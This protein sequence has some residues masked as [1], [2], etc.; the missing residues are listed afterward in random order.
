LIKRENIDSLLSLTREHNYGFFTR[1]D[2]LTVVLPDS[3]FPSV[4]IVAQAAGLPV[5][6]GTNDHS[7]ATVADFHRIP[8]TCNT[9]WI[10]KE[11]PQDS[12]GN[13]CRQRENQKS[14]I[15]SFAA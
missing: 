11:Q 7:G 14:M 2:I 6:A 4:R 1:K 13:A 8:L 12:T 15:A 9:Y 10:V 3:A 5:K